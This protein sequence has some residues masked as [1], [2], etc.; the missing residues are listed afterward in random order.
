MK[1]VQVRMMYEGRVMINYGYC[2]CI[3][4]VEELNA[5]HAQMEPTYRYGLVDAWDE[6]MKRRHTNS[7]LGGAV[8]AMTYLKGGSIA[9]NFC[10]VVDGA[11]MAKLKMLTKHGKIYIQPNMLGFF[12][13]AD[14]IV[15]YG[16][17]VY[18]D[19]IAEAPRAR[20]EKPQ[21]IKWPGGKHYYVKVGAVD[22]VVDGEQKW[23][24]F[25]QAQRAWKQWE[26]ENG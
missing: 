5:Y 26:A 15:E 11:Y 12:I 23:D 25:E 22:V 17:P 4:S 13:P 8:S 18:R 20:V 21:Y 3:S 24:T 6:A 2:L 14:N 7:Y 10:S 9:E 19:F 16:E 1:F